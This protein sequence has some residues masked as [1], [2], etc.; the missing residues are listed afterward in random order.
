MSKEVYNPQFAVTTVD[1]DGRLTTKAADMSIYREA[2]DKRISP[3]EVFNARFPTD[4]VDA[5]GTPFEQACYAAGMFVNADRR[6]GHKPPTLHELRGGQYEVSMAGIVAPDGSS[7]LTVGGRL[8]FPMTILQWV[9][10]RLLVDNTAYEAA[11][12]DLIFTT[13]S[14]DG[15]RYDTPTINFTAP[16]LSR[17]QPRAQGDEPDVMATIGVSD[18]TQRIKTRSIGLSI[19][20]EAMQS[21]TLDLVGMV[22]REQGIGERAGRLDEDL[23]DII[24]GSAELGTSAIT[25]EHVDVYDASIVSSGVLTQ[26]AYLKILRKDWKKMGITHI[27]GDLDMNM[28]ISNRVGRPTVL[29]DP[30]TGRTDVGMDPRIMGIPDELKYFPTDDA[31]LGANVLIFLDKTKAL[32]KVISTTSTYAAVENFVLSRLQQF[33]FES[34]QRVERIFLDG[35]GIK[36]VLLTPT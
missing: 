33:I 7:A 22:L 9:S 32:R 8:L 21:T 19:T 6:M 17:M 1:P 29:G 26:K 20:D 3:V 2:F 30:G 27:I 16:R 25:A 4:D 11:F 10:D 18:Q 13:V 35:R 14:I 31:F 24:N 34:G 15:T 36:K 23:L 12:E 28:V 5:R